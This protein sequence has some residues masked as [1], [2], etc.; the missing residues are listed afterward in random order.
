MHEGQQAQSMRTPHAQGAAS[1]P[2]VYAPEPVR[3]GGGPALAPGSPTTAA[4]AA[5]QHAVRP[6]ASPFTAASQR[7]FSEDGQEP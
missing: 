6:M 2:E 5:A 3:E 4:P 7:R 1:A